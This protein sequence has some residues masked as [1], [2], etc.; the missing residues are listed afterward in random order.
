MLPMAEKERNAWGTTK[1]E[2]RRKKTPIFLSTFEA[3]KAEVK[4]EI[5]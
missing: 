3:F 1:A 5:F 4:A 2:E